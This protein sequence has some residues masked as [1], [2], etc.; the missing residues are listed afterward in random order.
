MKIHSKK[1]YLKI[2]YLLLL[3]VPILWFSQ[4]K[5]N[6]IKAPELVFDEKTGFVTRNIFHTHCNISLQLEEIKVFQEQDDKAFIE[7]RE[8]H[9]K[10]CEK[11]TI[12]ELYYHRINHEV[13]RYALVHGLS[14]K[15]EYQ[16]FIKN[17]VV[18]K[19]MMKKYSKYLKGSIEKEIW[20]NETIDYHYVIRE[21]GLQTKLESDSFNIEFFPAENYLK[22]YN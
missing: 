5:L 3:A 4:C 14:L 15:T 22:L 7:L 12:Q 13:K 20:Q 2:L 21:K 10:F 9:W 8:K 16:Q 6:Q 19:R 17:L 18:P 1:V 11:K